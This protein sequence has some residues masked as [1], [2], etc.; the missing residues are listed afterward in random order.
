MKEASPEIAYITTLL[1]DSMIRLAG[2]T[3]LYAN[4]TT[5][6]IAIETTKDEDGLTSLK[7]LL[8][9][10]FHT[11]QQGRSHTGASAPTWF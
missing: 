9:L 10:F 6:E 1:F 5:I 4:S 8:F 3:Q 11:N 2:F 7:T